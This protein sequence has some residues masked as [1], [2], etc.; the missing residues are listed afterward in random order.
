[1]S[2]DQKLK[3]PCKKCGKTLFFYVSDGENATSNCAT[4]EI[5]CRNRECKELNLVKI[6]GKVCD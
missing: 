6:C 2:T 5:K 3:V 1:M 4:V